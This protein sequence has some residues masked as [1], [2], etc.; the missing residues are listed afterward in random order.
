M[1]ISETR[2]LKEIMD[3]STERVKMEGAHASRVG[4]QLTKRPS[5]Y[6]RHDAARFPRSASFPQNVNRQPPLLPR[7][8][9]HLRS[10]TNL[11]SIA[12]LAVQNVLDRPAHYT[13]L[14]R[15]QEPQRWLVRSRPNF[16]S[17]NTHQ[18]LLCP[19]CHC[20]NVIRSP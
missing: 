11:F 6:L 18:P 13:P 19:I 17:A 15:V 3:K 4:Q 5:A 20:T 12:I 10:S 1:L 16:L 9:V 14:A 7:D 8:A 2:W